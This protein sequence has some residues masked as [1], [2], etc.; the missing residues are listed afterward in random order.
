MLVTCARLQIWTWPNVTLWRGSL[1]VDDV[2]MDH[3]QEDMVMAKHILLQEPPWF[4]CVRN[5]RT[6]SV[7]TTSPTTSQTASRSAESLSAA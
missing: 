7:W 4:E 1:E 5:R 6:C 2:A 3:D